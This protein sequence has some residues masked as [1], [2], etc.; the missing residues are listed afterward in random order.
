MN[1]QEGAEPRIRLGVLVRP[2]GTDGALRCLPAGEIVPRVVAPCDAWLGFSE[3]FLSPVRLL[4]CAPHGGALICTFEGA[5]SRNAADELVD[6]ALYVAESSLIFDT[7][8]AHPGLVGAE[9]VDESGKV[10]G[11]LVAIGRT[12]AHDLWTIRCADGVERLLPAVEAFVVDIDRPTH[13]VTVRTIP[14]LLEDEA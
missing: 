3:R 5:S 9:V 6:R 7:P 10:L 11:E 8:Y 1:T 13:C 4:T 12:R 2:F 14:G